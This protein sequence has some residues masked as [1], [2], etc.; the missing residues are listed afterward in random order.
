MFFISLLSFILTAAE[1]VTDYNALEDDVLFYEQ[2]TMG[3][4]MCRAI[5][6]IDDNVVESLEEFRVVLNPRSSIGVDVQY[7]PRRT[8]VLIIDDD[9]PSK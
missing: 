3:Q 1:E 5:T 2:R 9:T 6:I 7:A 4:T 8:T